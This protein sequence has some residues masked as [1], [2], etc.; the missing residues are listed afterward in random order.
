MGQIKIF[1]DYNKINLKSPTGRME[2]FGALTAFMRQPI[3]VH[4][5]LIEMGT[6][7]FTS[8]SDFAAEAKALI[9]RIHLDV[10]AADVGYLSFFDTR[11][12]KGVPAPG[13]SVRDVQSGLTFSKRG[14][15]GKADIYRVTG[16]EAFV[17]FDMYGG[18]LE[19]DQ[20]WF[21]DQQ[22]W[23]IEDTSIEFRAKWYKDKA[24]T[25]YTMI[26]AV[27]SE[28]DVVYD[29]T[30]ATAVEKDIITLNTAA[31]ALLTELDAAGYDVSPQTVVKVLCPLQLK[32]RLERALAAQYLTAGVVNAAA[33]VEY[34]I[35]PV[36]SMRV[37]NAGE[38][39]TDKWYM[40]V[41]GLKNKIGEK[42]DLTVLAE[43]NIQTYATTSVGWGR[44]GAYLNEAQFKRI[45]TA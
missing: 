37:M 18:G 21:D 1:S 8:T 20:A 38:A 29:A 36:Y 27:S 24:T 45:A 23:S 25:F 41:P 7:Q 44:Y 4:E 5:K 30:G 17:P 12:F 19:F 2:F 16:N 31:A 40:G 43:F 42:M 3:A 10:K 9:E 28:R 22:W 32:G 34:N 26:G 35:E 15:G 14:E 39:C 6:T 11:D 33:K 13:F